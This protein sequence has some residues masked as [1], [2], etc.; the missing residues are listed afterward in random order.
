LNYQDAKEMKRFPVHFD[1]KMVKQ[2]DFINKTAINSQDSFKAI[3]ENHINFM[4]NFN[5]KGIIR[6]QRVIEE[7]LKLM[8]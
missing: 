5:E 3:E 7:Q 8:D 1:K 6:Q 2:N 4:A